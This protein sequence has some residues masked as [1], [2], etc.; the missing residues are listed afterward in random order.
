M[1]PQ[2]GAE[3]QIELYRNMTGRERL[4]IA[5]QLWE[6]SVALMRAS[7]KRMNPGLSDQEIERRVRQ[8]IRDGAV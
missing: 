8:R 6:T 1:N 5:C 7:E 3:K 4:R 2:E